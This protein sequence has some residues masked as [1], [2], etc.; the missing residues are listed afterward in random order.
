VRVHSE[1]RP[2]S[3]YLLTAQTVIKS[4]VGIEIEVPDSATNGELYTPVGITGWQQPL[5]S[6]DLAVA[7]YVEASGR[8]HHAVWMDAI[9]P[10]APDLGA[11]IYYVG[12]FAPLA[13]PMARSGTV[14]A[15]D[16]DGIVHSGGTYDFPAHLVECRSYRGFSGS[17]CTMEVA[18]AKLSTND[19]PDWVPQND[20]PLGGMRYYTLLCDMF[21]SHFSD[22]A[23]LEAEKAVSCY[24]VGVMLPSRLIL[25]ALCSVL[26]GSG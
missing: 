12:I 6:V 21:T 15:L 19:A 14:G 22:E 16:Q 4:R 2:P 24:G 26:D 1:D 9:W 23:N 17:P 7:P 13:R 25:E 11:Q 3:G 5:D 8:D 10:G 20:R 18:F